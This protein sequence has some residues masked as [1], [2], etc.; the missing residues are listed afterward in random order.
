[1]NE[2][3]PA[4]AARDGSP[5]RCTGSA[6][7]LRR[8]RLNRSAAPWRRRRVS[9]VGASLEHLRCAAH[10]SLEQAAAEATIPPVR[11]KALERGTAEL[12]LTEGSRLAP[13]LLL[14]V[15]DLHKH[16]VRAEA[17][18]LVDIKMRT[19]AMPRNVTSPSTSAP[20]PG[21]SLRRRT[22]PWTRPFATDTEQTWDRFED[23][24]KA[25][26]LA[27]RRFYLDDHV[28][29]EL[30]RNFRAWTDVMLASGPD[31]IT[32]V[33]N[34]PGGGVIAGL[35]IVSQIRALQRAGIEVRGHVMGDAASMGAVI[36]ASCT[37]RSM[38]SLSRLMWHG[39]VSFTI[40]DQRD[41]RSQQ[42]EIA[43]MTTTIASILTATAQPGTK[44]ANKAW[45]RRVMADKRPTWIYPEEALKAGLVG[46]VVE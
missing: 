18:D 4:A 27:A 6:R 25:G 7:V 22:I 12:G 10:L 2:P 13:A 21:P 28:D 44:F 45:V 33:I 14:S 42:R 43:R 8:P 1:M 11:L 26:R 37:V 40:G 36:L 20:V 9:A 24:L 39:V 16:L 3:A 23:A 34:S 5:T 41:V 17:E 29:D 15:A 46:E 31:P 35:D 30:A 32:M 19:T 38:T